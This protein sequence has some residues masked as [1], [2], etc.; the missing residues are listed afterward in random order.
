MK[1][2]WSPEQISDKLKQLYSI[3]VSHE[4]ICHHAQEDKQ[5]GVKLY[6][7]PRRPKKYRKHTENGDQR[8]QI[9][10]KTSIEERLEV[11]ERRERIGDWEANTTISREHQGAIMTLMERKSRFLRM[12][13]V[14]NEKIFL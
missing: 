12:G 11:V 14:N 6:K 9:P 7:H 3:Q 2:D 10:N 4:W 8:G 5:Q 1:D 13:W